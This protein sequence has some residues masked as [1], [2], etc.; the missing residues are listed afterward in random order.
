MAFI[1]STATVKRGWSDIDYW[2]PGQAVTLFSLTTMI[3]WQFNVATHRGVQHGIALNDGGGSVRASLFVRHCCCFIRC[4]SEPSQASLNRSWT[5]HRQV[6]II[7][8]CGTCLDLRGKMISG[9]FLDYWWRDFDFF[10]WR[11]VLLARV[12]CDAGRARRIHRRNT[13]R[14]GSGWQLARM[15]GKQPRSLCRI[16]GSGSALTRWRR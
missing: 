11:A 4:R 16:P 14:C 2:Q 15:A 13:R 8:D 9:E 1:S 6:W 10:Y 12:D 7:L 3:V 5:S